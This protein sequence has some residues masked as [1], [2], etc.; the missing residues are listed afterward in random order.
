MFVHKDASRVSRLSHAA[1]LR[2]LVEVPAVASYLGRLSPAH[3]G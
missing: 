3:A 1:T 2:E